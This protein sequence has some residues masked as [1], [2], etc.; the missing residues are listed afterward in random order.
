MKA[1]KAILRHHKEVWKWKLKL[2]FYKM[3]IIIAIKF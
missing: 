2:I 1:L 3:L